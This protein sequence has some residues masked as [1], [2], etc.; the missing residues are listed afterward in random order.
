MRHGHE[1]SACGG[2]AGD[3]P[4]RALAVS[5]HARRRAHQGV[6]ARDLRRRRGARRR[7][8]PGAPRSLRRRGARACLRRAARRAAH[9]VVRRPRRARRR[10][11]RR[12][13]PSASTWRWSAAAPGPTWSTR[14]PGTPTS[15][16]TSPGC[17]TASRTSSPPT[18]LEPLRPWKAE[19]LGGGYAVS[20]WVERTAYEARPTGDRGVAR[21]CAT[22]CC[23]ATPTIDPARVHVV[24]NGIDT[25]GVGA[26][27][28]DPDRVRELGRRPGPAVG[29]LRRPDH[30]AEGPAAVPARGG[31]AAAGGAD[32]AVR[33]R[34]GHPRDRGRGASGWSTSCAAAR[35]GVVWIARDA[36]AR[37]RRPRC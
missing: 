28:H 25:D 31:R 12:C 1:T 20:S 8:G 2:S 13:G 36:A 34:A 27:S 21:R 11:R 29:G 32:R 3:Q 16:A 37:R 19:Q 24:H 33:R 26:A 35:T 15:P 4:V 17:C 22:T 6:P 30:P 7:A 18:R 10:Q 9:D 14:T 5:R 23:A